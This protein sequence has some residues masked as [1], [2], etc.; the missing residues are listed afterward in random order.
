MKNLKVL[1]LLVLVLMLVITG[2]SNGNNVANNEPKINASVNEPSVDEAPDAEVA[3]IDLGGRKIRVSAWWDEKPK[4]DTAGGKA[5]LARMDELEQKY[6]FEFEFINVP[7]EE[8]VDKFTTTVLAGEPFADIVMMQYKNAVIPVLQDQV[9]PLSEFTT[10]AN[11]INNEHKLLKKLPPL[12]GGEYAFNYPGVSVVG[13]HYNRDLFKQLGLPDP[14]E[15]YANGQWNWDEFLEISKKAT[16]DTDNDGKMDT[17]GYSGWAADIARHFAVTNG[18]TFIEGA[19]LTDT[20]DDPKVIEALEFVNRLF[21]VEGVVKSNTGNAMDW[22]ETNT[23]KDGDV[24]MSIQP[25]W[26]IGDLSF[27]VGVVPVPAGPNSDGVH[28][29]ANTGAQGW[30]IP[31]GVEDPQI[32]YQIFEEWRDVPSSEEY[33]GQDWLESRYKTEADIE[34]AL[35]HINGTDMTSLEEAVPDFTFY[36]IMDDIFINNQS[37]TA[38]IEKYKAEGVA[39]VNKMKQ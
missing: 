2:C 9:L 34:M 13:M 7:V 36:K 30:F 12:V 15:L 23:F 6:N 37:V 28:T 38:T 14:Q 27:E 25:D 4:D 26:N 32:V 31:K 18:I 21:N 39:A 20:S 35:E 1:S 19:T 33:L 10:P 17:F 29:Y 24:A 3:K 5:L 16:R 11:D 8:Y 22:G